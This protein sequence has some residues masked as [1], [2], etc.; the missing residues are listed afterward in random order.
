MYAFML[1]LMVLTTVYNAV[2]HL[3]LWQCNNNGILSVQIG[4]FVMHWQFPDEDTI[5]VDNTVRCS[6]NES[7]TQS[8]HIPI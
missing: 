5:E 6:C 7:V 8:F 1:S 4:D 3:S 2:P